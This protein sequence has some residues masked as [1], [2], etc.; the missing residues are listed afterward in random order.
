[1][2]KVGISKNL[3]Q[4]LKTH[5]RSRQSGLLGPDGDWDD[6]DVV[7]SKASIL[8]KHLYFDSS[9]TADFE[10]T[11]EGGRMCFLFE[12][13]KI[14]FEVTESRHKAREL[15]SALEKVSKYRYCGRV[16]NRKTEEEMNEMLTLSELLIHRGFVF[17]NSKSVKMM[18]HEDGTLD[19]PL[20]DFSD[21]HFQEYQSYQVH[22]RLE[23]EWLVSFVGWPRNQAK[24]KGIFKVGRRLEPGSCSISPDFPCKG[25]SVSIMKNCHFYDLEKDDRFTDLENRVIIE[26]PGIG[27]AFHLWYR[28]C[29]VLEVLPKTLERV[30]QDFSIS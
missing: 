17:A 1:M 30:F 15:E 27:H 29:P 8:T 10:L 23:C 3:R 2:L 18:R 28:D 22:K 16:L 25:P 9:L 7:R 4:R 12:K 11:K 14:R 5:A 20:S 21:K 26:W 24:F 19:V 13:C 6:P